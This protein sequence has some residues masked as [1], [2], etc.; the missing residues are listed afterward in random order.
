MICV[1][2]KNK[3]GDGV[4]FLPFNNNKRNAITI[5]RNYYKKGYSN[6]KVVK[7]DIEDLYIPVISDL[8]ELPTCTKN[9]LQ[10]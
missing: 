1:T 2:Y 4:V 7:V 8:E 6:V 5:A 9:R 10:R 3:R